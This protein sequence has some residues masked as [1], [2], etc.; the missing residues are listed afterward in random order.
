[1]RPV[2]LAAALALAGAIPALAQP[3]EMPPI[4][5]PRPFE[6][7]ATESF[8]LDNGLA[9]TLIPFGLAPKTT[10]SVSVRAGNLNDGS[11]T[12]ISDLT[13]E[14]LQ[15]GAAGRAPDEIARDAA[16]MGGQLDVAVGR[17]TT[18]FE[19]AVLSERGPDAVALIADVIRR[20]DLPESE[21]ERLK[22]DFRRSLSVSLASPGPVAD[23]ALL[24]AVYGAGH[25]YGRMLPSDAQLAAYTLADARAFYEAEYGARRTRIYVSGQFDARAMR[26][27]I[28]A[29]FG[30]WAAGP[31]PLA[32]PATLSSGPR[33]ILIDRPGAEQATLRLAIPVPATGAADDIPLRVMNALL[34]GSFTSRLVQNLREDKGYT[35]SPDADFDRTL[36]GAHWYFDADVATPVTGPALAET[37]GEI[38]RLAAETPPA[39]EG[40]GIRT[41]LAGVFVL[42]NAS[43]G[44]LIGQLAARDL[45]GLP[46]DWLEAYVPAVT[47]VSDADI[48]TMAREHLAIDR[49][50]LVAVGDLDAI[51]SDI[52]ALPELADAPVEVRD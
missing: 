1:M 51:E 25:P 12:W 9:V 8:T 24:E 19:I 30:D 3:T 35:Y 45:F 26:A 28:A 2:L 21:V 17:H 36:A 22:A 14:L 23:A 52:R 32:L 6:L 15:Q 16:G 5:A 10:I 33:V 40:Q 39:D 31:E 49:M 41:W 29:S 42:Q 4:G 43:P 7:P 47:A 48:S 46:E 27:A 18:N 37:F 11:Q 50:I 44:G 20:P 38:E 13:A 34:G